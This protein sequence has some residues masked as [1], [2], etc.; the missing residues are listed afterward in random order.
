LPA[1]PPPS[2]DGLF[3]L[4]VLACVIYGL[5]GSKPSLAA[6]FRFELVGTILII[7]LTLSPGRWFGVGAE[8]IFGVP[9]DWIFQAAG[10]VIV[11]WACGG[12]HVNPAVSFAFFLLGKVEA[13]EMAINLIAQTLGATIGVLCCQVFAKAA[14]WQ[15]LA[16]PEI[17][18]PL[19]GDALATAATTEFAASALLMVVV[20]ALN[21]EPST[22]VQG[23]WAYYIVKQTLTAAAIRGLIVCFPATGPAF[24]P[25]IATGWQVW[26]AGGK[27][28]AFAAFWQVYWLAAFAGAFAATAAYAA[29]SPQARFLGRAFR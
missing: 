29:Y 10:I 2:Y 14:G 6:A 7:V 13:S 1:Q 12:P 24:N 25:A 15:L 16:G 20:Y 8:P 17:A 22:R 28:P 11:D 26:K 3:W 23:H 9:V 21:F 5:A 19:S 4:I 27:L 18:G